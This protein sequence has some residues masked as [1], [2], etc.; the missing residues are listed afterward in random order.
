LQFYIKT[1]R[2]KMWKNDEKVDSSSITDSYDRRT[3]SLW[4]Q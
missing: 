1:I 2:R 4:Q 3:C